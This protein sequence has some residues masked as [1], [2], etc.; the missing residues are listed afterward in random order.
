[1]ASGPESESAYRRIGRAP[2]RLRD[3]ARS[4]RWNDLCVPT[5]QDAQP[6]SFHYEYS[7][8]WA[9]W[10]LDHGLPEL[11][12]TLGDEDEVPIAYW[13]G[14]VVGAVLFCS[15][16]AD[17]EEDTPT[18]A[19]REIDNVHYSYVRTGTGWEPTGASGGTGGPEDKPMQPPVLPHRLAYFGGGFQESG[20]PGS[21]RGR[22]GMVGGSARTIE[23]VDRHGTT[24]RP[25]EAPLGWVIVC[26]DPED[27]VTIRVLDD[28]GETL[29]ET[30]STPG[31]W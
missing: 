15:W 18:E 7:D 6:P 24:R 30:R 21:V 22:T 11:P 31:R 9:T 19:P 28:Q 20:P 4:A 10:V 16:R 29:A 1:M 27:E 14:P 26:F 12:R 3:T 8:D 25:V 13:A 2:G 5:G 17:C 23:L